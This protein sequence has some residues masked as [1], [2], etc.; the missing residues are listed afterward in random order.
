MSVNVSSEQSRKE[1]AERKDQVLRLLM[2][3]KDYYA[4]EGNT[5]K[6]EVFE[7]LF[8]DLENEEFSIVVVGEFSAGKST[9]LNALMGKRI[10]PSFSNE[11]TATVNFLRHK[12]KAQD[13]EAGRVF[14]SSGEQEIM[15]DANIDTIM[16]YVTTKGDD[17]A[18]N[19]AHLD[20][21]LDSP[22]LKD[23]VTL[24]DS[25]GLNGVAD[26]HREITENQ[27]LKSHASIFLF[28]SDHPGSKTDFEFLFELQSKVKTIIF[29]LNKIDAIKADEGE[30][31]ESIIETLKTT[32]KRKFPEATSIPEI[33]PVSAYQALVARNEDLMM[34]NNKAERTSEENDNLERIS[35]LKP[36][37]DRLLRFLTCGEKARQ[38]LIS[39]IEKVISIGDESRKAY[40][41]EISFLDKSSDTGEI[42]NQI[43][44][45]KESI[46]GLEK[47]IEDSR[48]D[49]EKQVREGIRDI[50]EKLSADMARLQEKKLT[51]I[52][53]YDDLE[54]LVEYLKTFENS[55]V[56]RV[57]HIAMEQDEQLKE[58][59]VSIIKMQCLS[60][61]DTIE[62]AL[63]NIDSEMS[64][65]VSDHL[66]SSEKMVEVG[67][68]EMDEKV[69]KLES[70]LEALTAE[71]AQAENDYFAAKKRERQREELKNDI[72]DLKGRKEIVESQMLPQVERYTREVNEKQYRGGILGAIGFLLL[73]GKNVT[74]HKQVVDSTA[75]EEAKVERDRK[76]E[77]LSQEIASK[78]NSLIAFN[79]L[80][81]EEAERI[82]LRKNAEL[83]AL[84]QKI[85]KQIA[86]NTKK[87]EE[88]Y[89]RQVKRIKRELTSYCD[90]ITEELEQQA[91]KELRKAEQ[92]YVQVVL[93]AVEGSLKEKLS[94]KEKRLEQ[95]EKQLEESE[96]NRNNRIMC[97]NEKI[98][99]IGELIGEAIDLETD[100]SS[101]EVDEI[102]QEIL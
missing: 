89:D 82:Q 63:V 11:T 92:S 83:E 28:N 33:W 60:Q 1:Y 32:Y 35:R 5:E 30:T 74:T 25:P 15:N 101:R 77:E 19:I 14:Y 72:L 8:N 52:E 20:L 71:V 81:A 70:Q 37:E 38:Q 2:N 21:Y 67:L 53:S 48:S 39:P 100:L 31:P 42:D 68:R 76:V 27:I 96:D 54:D 90:L 62:K 98:E 50:R 61:A 6:A 78:Q 86:Q 80:D 10:L 91:K 93:S 3:A 58:K 43:A 64:F 66:D 16:Q 7:K 85:E 44:A 22:F 4:E 51:Q 24:V 29:V 41:E 49:V 97:L 55:F 18:K 95:L 23:G 94:E 79:G 46:E 45:V 88:N 99:K 87:I 102:K 73:G 34:Y 13:G 26:G 84:Q 40:L 17:V 69:K 47:Q 59:I 36:F 57:Q 9:L 75:R 65:S 56:Q 12:D